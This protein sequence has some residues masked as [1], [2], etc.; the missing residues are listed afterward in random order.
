MA[1]DTANMCMGVVGPNKL[2]IYKTT[3]TLNSATV[4]SYF[5]TACPGLA[6]GDFMIVKTADNVELVYVTALSAAGVSLVRTL[7]V[8]ASALG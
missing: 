5:T 2:W 4:K 7:G 6:I 3:D 8:A 1:F